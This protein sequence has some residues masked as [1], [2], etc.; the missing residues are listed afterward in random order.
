MLVKELIQKL[1]EFDQ[2]AEVI[3]T[4]EG[5]T[6]KLDV[7]RAFN[8]RI[9]VDADENSY[10]EHWQR[11]SRLASMILDCRTVSGVMRVI[12][13]REGDFA[14]TIMSI[15]CDSQNHKL[16]RMHAYCRGSYDL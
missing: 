1:L 10:K 15:G 14:N 7:Y 3:G 16:H 8:G 6:M 5:I 9:M 2:E 11:P 4:W 13:G 12:D